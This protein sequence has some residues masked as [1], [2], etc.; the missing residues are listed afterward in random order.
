MGKSHLG[1]VVINQKNKLY[2]LNTIT[3][4]NDGSIHIIPNA[5]KDS[6]LAQ[7]KGTYH[8]SGFRHFT[9]EKEGRKQEIFPKWKK[10][11]EETT[12][13]EGLMNFTIK[14]L[15]KRGI[16]FLDEFTKLN[17]YKN[18]IKIDAKKYTH[19]TVQYFLAKKDFDT[20]KSSYLYE[21]VFEIELA[22]NKLL[23]A[24]RNSKNTMELLKIYLHI[25]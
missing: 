5:S 13:S 14:N 8:T 2:R 20:S 21:E 7:F 1:V 11:H 23:I 22:N 4:S 9:N 25:N 6:N 16:S 12:Q 24:T 15:N 3:T 19:L 18:V 10:S 17:K